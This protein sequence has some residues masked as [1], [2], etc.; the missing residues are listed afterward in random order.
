MIVTVIVNLH[1]R[2]GSS[3]D[4]LRILLAGR[5]GARIAAGCESFEVHQ[6]EDDPTRF[7]MVERWVSRE[8]HREHFEAH[9]MKTGVLDKATELM[10]EPLAPPVYFSLVR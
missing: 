4:L 8:A 2:P 7:V 9:V 5:D 1:A 10:E 3:D 6:A